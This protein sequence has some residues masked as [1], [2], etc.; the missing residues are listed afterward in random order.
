MH[1]CLGLSLLYA[2]FSINHAAVGSEFGSGFRSGKI[3][4][5]CDPEESRS[6]TG[7]RLQTKPSSHSA[8]LTA[9]LTNKLDSELCESCQTLSTVKLLRDICV[10][11]RV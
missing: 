2:K 8:N 4:H 10:K 11:P 9:L 6:N 1:K 7:C 3:I 5:N